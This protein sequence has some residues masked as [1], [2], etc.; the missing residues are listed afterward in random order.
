M[1]VTGLDGVY[2]YT[3]ER[4]LKMLR[5]NQES[6]LAVLEAFVYDPVINWRLVEGM[7]K[8]PK[9]KKETTVRGGTILPSTSTTD[10]IM[11]TIKRKLEGKKADEKCIIVE[12]M[13]SEANK[14]YYFRNRIQPYRWIKSK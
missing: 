14:F 5:T 10:S 2:N 8:D 6:L 12:N 3:A 9:T 1:E 4:V 11:D 13:Y 7:K